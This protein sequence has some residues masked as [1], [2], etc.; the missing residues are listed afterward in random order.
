[1]KVKLRKCPCCGNY[2]LWD[3]CFGICNVCFWECG[4]IENDPTRYHPDVPDGANDVSLTQARR[5]Y[6]T[7][8]A[9]SQRLRPFVALPEEYERTESDEPYIIVDI[10]PPDMEEL[11]RRMTAVLDGR[12]TRSHLAAW[13]ERFIDCGILPEGENHAEIEWTLRQIMLI[14]SDDDEAQDNCDI[15]EWLEK[16]E[17]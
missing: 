15:T 12:M 5:N 2:T 16:I 8:G 3:K 14:T 6:Q 9:M 4:D 13:A 10:Q 11:K 7:F 17:H 1:M